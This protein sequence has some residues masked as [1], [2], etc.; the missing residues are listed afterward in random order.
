LWLD[1]LIIRASIQFNEHSSPLETLAAEFVIIFQ[2]L[3]SW[4]LFAAASQ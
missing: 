3:A 4:N 1:F 2:D